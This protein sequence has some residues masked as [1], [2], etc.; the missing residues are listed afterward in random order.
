LPCSDIKTPGLP[1]GLSGDPG[2]AP[3][4]KN[5]EAV[6]G[7]G[8]EGDG[9]YTVDRDPTD[10][11]QPFEEVIAVSATRGFEAP[12]LIHGDNILVDG[13]RL[14]YLNVTNA[15]VPATIAFGSLPGAVDPLFPIR[16]A[17]LSEFTPAI[18][19]GIAGEVDT[20]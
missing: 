9:A 18:V 5:G 3:I 8:I 19:G 13:I 15:P 16:A 11:D 2:S 20:R 17:Q 10:F 7:V 14:A 12:A 1:L 4:Y 6:G